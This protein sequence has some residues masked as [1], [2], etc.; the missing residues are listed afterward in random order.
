MPQT[1]ISESGYR[2]L[3]KIAEDTHRTS[4]QVLDEALDRL[5]REH[6]LDALNAGYVRL[7]ENPAAWADEQ[8][9]RQLW[10]ATLADGS[11]RER[12]AP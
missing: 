3:R 4:E 7:R 11:N 6:L 2:T 9:E 5:E 12:V 8:A 1:R 10:D